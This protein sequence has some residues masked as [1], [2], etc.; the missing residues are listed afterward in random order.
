MTYNQKIW[1]VLP[2]RCLLFITVFSFCS[3][4]T[5]RNLTEITQWWTIL[6]SMIN[7]VTIVVL[8]IICKHD[9]TTFREMIHYE[10]KREFEIFSVN[11]VLL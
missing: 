11:S 2:M 7:I 10:K 5:K 9:N 4:I 3:I 8:W 6:A 1:F